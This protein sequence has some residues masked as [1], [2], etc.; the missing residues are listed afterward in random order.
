EHGQRSFMWRG[1]EDRSEVPHAARLFDDEGPRGSPPPGHPPPPQ[2]KTKH[3]PPTHEFQGPYTTVQQKRWGEP[4]PASRPA[5]TALAE[6]RPG[7]STRPRAR[8]G[9]DGSARR[10][11]RRSGRRGRR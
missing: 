5:P 11:T 2:N 3:P 10:G 1:R 6:T 9:P 7:W 8:R 4:R